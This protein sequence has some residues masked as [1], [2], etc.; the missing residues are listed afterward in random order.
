MRVSIAGLALNFVAIP[1]MT[2]VQV[3]G[4]LALLLGGA[5]PMLGRGVAAVTAWGANAIIESTRVVDLVPWLSWRVPSPSLFAV[6][7]F[8]FAAWCW[9]RCPARPGRGRAAAVS[10]AVCLLSIVTAPLTQW[11]QPAHGWLRVTMFDVGQGEGLLLQAPGG[12][13][14]LVDA[15][16]RSPHLDIGD[17]VLMPGL[18][19]S[20]LRALDALAFTHGDL[21]H[22]GGALSVAR[23]FGPREIWEGVPVLRDSKR[24]ALATFASDRAIPWRPLQRG[25]VL[26]I[27][28]LTITALHPPA[29]T[30]ERQR[31]RNDDSV[32][33]RLRYRDVEFLLTGD[34]GEEVEADLALD[35]SAP[36]RILKVGHH[37]SRSSTSPSLLRRFA[38]H[39]ALISAG[40]GNPF[41]H[42]SAEVTARLVRAGV[43]VFRTN[44]DGAIIVETDGHEVRVRTVTGRAWTMREWRARV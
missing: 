23:Q 14:L 37:G 25:D 24:Q 13:S 29:P 5:M 3:C 34:I 43:R 30:W 26:A 18:W 31:V 42:P 19:A 20:G 22:I 11:A 41:G 33:L 6:A 8:Y 40:R 16:G 35:A 1:M 36:L 7:S 2:V 21:D 4:A 32:V 28:E 39:A 17:R 10:L 44:Q 9:I 38:P 27:G 12:Y 15:G